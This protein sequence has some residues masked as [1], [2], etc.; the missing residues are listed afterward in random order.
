MQDKPCPKCEILPSFPEGRVDVVIFSSVDFLLQ[1]VAKLLSDEGFLFSLLQSQI[2]IPKTNFGELI[3][4][5][6][7]HPFSEAEKEELKMGYLHEGENLLNVISRLRPLKI[8]LE[9]LKYSEYLDILSN[10]RLTVH[11]QPVVDLK[12]KKVYG[13][14][15]LIRGV[16]GNGEIL[17]PA[18]LFEA[19]RATDTLF[20]LDRACRETAIKTAAV[21]GLKGYKVFIN[22]L[23][24][25]IY[26]PAFCLQ[27]TVKWAYQLEWNPEHL[28]FEV[29]ETEKVKDFSHLANILD[30]YRENGFKTALDDVGTGYSSI[31]ALIKLK[32][33]FVKLGKELVED[34]DKSDIKRD[35]MKAVVK[36]LHPHGIKVIA[37]GVERVE[38]L[39]FLLEAGVDFAQGFLFARPNPEPIYELDLDFLS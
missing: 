4:R 19:A 33:D 28:V 36:A 25:V 24:T 32:P 23:P 18:Y 7:G 37:E 21:K 20:Y 8:Y 30:Y 6:S 3:N 9:I 1:K 27:S 17:S 11:F 15:C 12:K 31:D 5:L 34:I 13:F 2:I 29:V 35:L 16:R 10:L 38:E 14:E 26:D 22:F 39:R